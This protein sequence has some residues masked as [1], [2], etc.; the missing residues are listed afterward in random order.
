LWGSGGL[1]SALV[2]NRTGS[3]TITLSVTNG[4]GETYTKNCTLNFDFNENPVLENF[5]ITIDGISLSK[6]SY[7]KEG[8]KIG[9]SGTVKSYN[10]KFSYALSLLEETCYSKTSGTTDSY[11]T[12]P[13]TYNSSTKG[14]DKNPYAVLLNESGYVL[15]PKQVSSSGPFTISITTNRGK[16][17]KDSSSI[18]IKKYVASQIHFTELKYS[19]SDGANGSLTGSFVVD[20]YGYDNDTNGIIR[21]VYTQDAGKNYTL[22]SN[23]NGSYSFSISFPNFTEAYKL[24]API[25]VT[26]L[27]AVYTENGASK[28]VATTEKTTNAL[29]YLAVYNMLPTVAYRQN[30]LGINTNNPDWNGN[31]KLANTAVTISGYNNNQRVYLVSG[32]HTSYINLLTGS[33]YGFVLDGGSW[34]GTSG[35]IIVPGG[36]NIPTDLATI[37]YTGEIG[38]LE[39]TRQDVIIFS[40]GS[41][42]TA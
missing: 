13:W 36:S 22:W 11:K 16:I 9:F 6:F 28:T 7:I 5:N 8:V 26:E 35:E 31:Q 15:Q 41:A 25:C 38:D 10:A 18:A 39:Q 23:G 32:S 24:L 1:A 20:E 37:A 17:I 2:G 30:Y 21:K 4:F 19:P 34:D 33:L 42:P 12:D 40:G 3:K 29:V 14:W 27:S